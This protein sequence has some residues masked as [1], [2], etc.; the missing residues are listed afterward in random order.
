MKMTLSTSHATAQHTPGPWHV[1]TYGEGSASFYAVKRGPATICRVVE[2]DPMLDR[3]G[4]A[5]ARLI[6]AAPDL[7]AACKE[8]LA[9]LNNPDA[10]GY[11]ADQIDGILNRA[12]Q[13]ATA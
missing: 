2:V 12:I 8:A 6:A 10:D 4:D 11:D 13:R 7:L 1:A 9:L 3:T 5:N